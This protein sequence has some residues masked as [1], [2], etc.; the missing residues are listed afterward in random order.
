M[1]VK[2]IAS[3]SLVV[4]LAFAVSLAQGVDPDAIKRRA[5]ALAQAG[6]YAQARADLE[7][8]VSAWPDNRLA[9]KL[10]ARV[11]IAANA[12]SDAATH[13]ERLVRTDGTD[14]EAWSLLGRLHQ[15]AQRFG[16]AAR[17]LDRAVRLDASDVAALTALAN[18]YVGL[19]LIEMADATFARA[20]Q[21]NARR[22]QPAVE[23]HASY[24]VFLLRV[25][26]REEAE[27]Q[28]RRAA[29]IDPA[30]P[31]VRDA[32]RA[33]EDRADATARRQA[34]RTLAATGTMAD[35][36]R[37]AQALRDPDRAVRMLADAALWEV[38][39]RSGD[40]EIDRLFAAGV[41][42]MGRGRESVGH[43][44]GRS[45]GAARRPAW[46]SACAISAAPTR[47]GTVPASAHWPSY[48]GANRPPPGM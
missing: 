12:T 31:L 17:A 15:D 35:V 4:I 34:L 33:L 6:D 44:R 21:T 2:R 20:I 3:G 27:A 42:E 32:L 39:S 9:R 24:A 48:T 8:L 29:A 30:H 28:V 26:R 45:T 23:P 46:S 18:A 5:L 13:L 43:S 11:L 22:S 37:I 36:P 7:R 10:L 41:Q 16:E 1:A 19:G 14:A 47:L 25:N 38:W 40:A